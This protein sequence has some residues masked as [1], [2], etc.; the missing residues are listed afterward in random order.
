[1]ILRGLIQTV[2]TI[3]LVQLVPA[4][5]ATLE[6]RAE[7]PTSPSRSAIAV[8]SVVS[9]ALPVALE[10][11]PTRLDE[12]SLG[13]VTSA[14][15]ALVV[16]RQT[17]LPLYAKNSSAVRSIGSITKLM[18][19]L[20][21]LDTVP[22]LASTAAQLS[23][24]YRPGGRVYLASNDLVTV[25]DLLLASL[26]GSDNSATMSLVR[27]SGKSEKD[28]VAQM[29]ARALELGMASSVFHD[30]TGLSPRNVSTAEDI[31]RLLEAVQVNSTI[32]GAIVLPEVTITQGSG[33]TVTI[34]STDELLVSYINQPPF[35]M[36]GGKTGYLPEAGYC[37]GIGVSREG[38]GDIFIVLLG[39]DS[40]DSRV[41]EAKGLASWAYRVFAW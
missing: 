21:F 23:E 27:L 30:P 8:S 32:A 18:T 29:N 28:F 3:S 15:S 34:P 24:D 31:V 22:D 41:Q 11:A 26:V 12:E 19:A 25:N 14:E 40:K 33:R 20:V 7:L 16:D 6:R 39:S 35:K 36:L 2:L 13:V 1:M 5:S 37:I 38:A 17:G 10:R 9:V 4:D